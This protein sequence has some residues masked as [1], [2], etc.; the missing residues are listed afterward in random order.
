[1]VRA[2]PAV[3]FSVF[4]LLQCSALRHL[5]VIAISS[6]SSWCVNAALEAVGLG[7]AGGWVWFPLCL[8]ILVSFCELNG[9]GVASNRRS[10]KSRVA[11][12]LRR[13]LFFLT[14]YVC[15]KWMRT[16]A[17]RR[18]R[19]RK[20]YPNTKRTC[21]TRRLKRRPIFS[22]SRDSST[23]KTAVSSREKRWSRG[24]RWNSRTF[25]KYGTL[26]FFFQTFP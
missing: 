13:V 23:T 15:R 10:S 17:H 18:K 22:A 11:V 4:S 2:S 21:S 8:L 9:R 14:L 7:M 5:C 19:N 3:V 1:M 26:Q 16:T 25:G 24:T 12:I 20:E 6:C